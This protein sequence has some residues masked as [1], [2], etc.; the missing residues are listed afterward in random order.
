MLFLFTLQPVQIVSNLP[1][2]NHCGMLACPEWP[3]PTTGERLEPKRP[4]RHDGMAADRNRLFPRSTLTL[5][6]AGELAP[7]EEEERRDSLRPSPV[8]G[9][10]AWQQRVR[11]VTL[12]D[13]SA[14]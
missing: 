2:S 6:L 1:E 13:S 10:D 3:T 11:L 7:E 8:Q 12:S 9:S 5:A 14:G 4:F